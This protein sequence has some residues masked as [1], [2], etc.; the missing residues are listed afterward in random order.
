M[1]LAKVTNQPVLYIPD[2]LAPNIV[3]PVTT[4]SEPPV[5]ALKEAPLM[6]VL[7]TGEFVPPTQIVVA[8]PAKKAVLPTTASNLPWLAL[9]GLLSLC[10]GLWFRGLCAR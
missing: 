6:A 3:A 1:A 10:A 8:P 9:M 4:A 2:E 7:P 5:I